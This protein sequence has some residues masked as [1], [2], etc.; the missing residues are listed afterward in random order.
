MK[1]DGPGFCQPS[2]QVSERPEDEQDAQEMI[3]RVSE[4]LMT[5]DPR[6]CKMVRYAESF[7]SDCNRVSEDDEDFDLPTTYHTYGMN[8]VSWRSKASAWQLAKNAVDC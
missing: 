3:R 8:E 7:G 5:I 2:E 4:A 6:L 1:R